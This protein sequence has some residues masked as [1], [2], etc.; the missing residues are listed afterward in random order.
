MNVWFAGKWNSTHRVY[1]RE[2]M[3][4]MPMLLRPG[5]IIE[6]MDAPQLWSRA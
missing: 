5:P 6:Q 4:F 1:A 3:P 2:R